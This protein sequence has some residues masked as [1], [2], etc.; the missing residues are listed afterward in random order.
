[1]FYSVVKLFYI[2]ILMFY[3]VLQCGSHF[4]SIIQ[5]FLQFGSDVLQC[6]SGVFYSL[7]HVFLTVWFRCFTV[8]F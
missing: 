3:S 1:M 8:G 6:G 2:A 5:F 4:C 7:V